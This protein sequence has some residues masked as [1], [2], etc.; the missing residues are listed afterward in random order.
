MKSEQDGKVSKI[1]LITNTIYKIDFTVEIPTLKARK[2]ELTNKIETLKQVSW[3]S[4]QSK[5]K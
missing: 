3:Q 2:M 4:C 5:L 1:L